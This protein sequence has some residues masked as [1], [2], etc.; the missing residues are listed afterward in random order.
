M[1]YFTLELDPESNYSYK[2]NK[3]SSDI[4]DFDNFNITI[5]CTEIDILDGGSID[6]W[7]LS[8]FDVYSGNVYKILGSDGY[9]AT[10]IDYEEIYDVDTFLDYESKESI[11]KIDNL[12]YIKGHLEDIQDRTGKILCDICEVDI[13]VYS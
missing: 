1:I 13:P 2:I 10:V 9:I 7:E 4:K 11:I 8:D 3:I 5:F 6:F 12:T